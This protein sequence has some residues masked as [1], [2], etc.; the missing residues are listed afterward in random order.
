MQTIYSLALIGLVGVNAIR[1]TTNES[2]FTLDAGLSL[3][4]GVTIGKAEFKQHSNVSR[5]SFVADKPGTRLLPQFQKAKVIPKPAPVVQNTVT[6]TPVVIQ[7]VVHPTPA[8]VVQDTVTPAPV[9]VEEVVH[10][11]P[12]PV[13]QNTVTPAPVVVEEVVHPTPAPVVQ[14]TVKPAPV[15][16]EEV[17]EP[18][19]IVEDTVKPEPVVIQEKV[20]PTPAP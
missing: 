18:V 12:A 14:E 11:S 10:P 19:P 6:P 13:V 8:P 17:I 4:I 1:L 7:E 16:V 3:P 9:V 2:I 15:V 20:E 5:Q